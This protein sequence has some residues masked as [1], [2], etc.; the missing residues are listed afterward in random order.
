MGTLEDAQFANQLGHLYQL[1]AQQIGDYLANN[2]DELTKEEID[3]I[4]N[5][6]TEI[7]SYANTFYSLSDN[8]AFTGSDQYFN[9][10]NDASGQIN[11]ALNHLDN[12]NKIIN[13]SAGII[14]LAAAVMTGNGPVIVTSIATIVSFTKSLGSSSS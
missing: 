14:T 1:V 12:I 3:T 11:D 8:I 2:I 6:Q 13:I 4:N 7:I 9:Q 5:Y 10:I